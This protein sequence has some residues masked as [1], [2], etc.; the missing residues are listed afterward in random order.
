MVVKWKRPDEKKDS[1][2]GGGGDD[3]HEVV[4]EFGISEWKVQV[5][6]VD[7]RVLLYIKEK[8]TSGKDDGD[9]FTFYYVIENPSIH[10]LTFVSELT[11]FDKLWQ[12][13]T[14]A[15]ENGE[16]ED[17]DMQKYLNSKPFTVDPNYRKIIQFQLKKV[18]QNSGSDSASDAV[19]LPTFKLFDINYKV[20]L[21]VV[22]TQS[23]VKLKDGNLYL[24]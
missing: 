9:Y 14:S 11:N 5:P 23:N 17:N 7:P 19:K 1:S 2:S 10:S 18:E 21:Y 3:D 13:D 6:L 24:L 22:P 20:Y 8:L 4:N 12:L 15:D 16:D